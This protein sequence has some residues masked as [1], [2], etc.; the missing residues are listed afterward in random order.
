MAVSFAASTPGSDE[1]WQKTLA[2]YKTDFETTVGLVR[3]VEPDL[4]WCRHS[5]DMALSN[6][7]DMHLTRCSLI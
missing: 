4:T 5:A 1:A 3:C 7:R 6:R 2:V